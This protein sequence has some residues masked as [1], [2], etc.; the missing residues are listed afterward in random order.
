MLV[1]LTAFMLD[2]QNISLPC[3]AFFAMNLFVLR[4]IP[5]NITGGQS[6]KLEGK[7][8]QL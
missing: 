6:S 7:N 3:S 8:P 4:Q 1:V 2:S 5:T